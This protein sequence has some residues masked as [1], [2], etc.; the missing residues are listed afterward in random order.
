MNAWI[1][2]FTLIVGSGLLWVGDLIKQWIGRKDDRATLQADIELYGKLG[3]EFT[4]RSELALSINE[5]VK[6]IAAL[7][8]TTTEPS[9]PDEFA[10]AMKKAN[11]L[12]GQSFFVYAVGGGLVTYTGTRI[13]TYGMTA[14]LTFGLLVGFAIAA[15]GIWLLLR[16]GSKRREI[17]LAQSQFTIDRIFDTH[18]RERRGQDSAPPAE[19]S[20]T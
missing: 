6:K 14:L 15:F 12:R 10:A 16:S 4:C 17:R 11:R 5:R 20:A 2:I 13:I 1:P 18:L 8:A 3:A 9:T 7:P 19:E